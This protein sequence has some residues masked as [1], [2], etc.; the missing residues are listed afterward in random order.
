MTIGAYDGVHIGHRRVIDQVRRRAAAEGLRSVVVTFDR[1]PAA[2]VHPASAPALLTDADQKLDL[3]EATGVDQVLVLQFDDERSKEP[4]EDFVREVLIAELGA[5]IVVVGDDF[6]FGHERRGNVELLR[7]MGADGGFVVEP[8]HLIE[9][10]GAHEVVSSTRIRS[11]V[12]KG[13]LTDAA[14]LLG[15]PHEVRGTPVAASEGPG[16][17]AVAGDP[18][19]RSVVVVPAGIALPPTGRYEG[20]V[21][22]ELGAVPADLI[23]SSSQGDDP[24][25]VEV[26]LLGPGGRLLDGAGAVRLRF[27]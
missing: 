15:R 27:G 22:D 26:G 18:R 24:Q 6:H 10:E 13:A 19:R 16:E 12:A 8:V 5:R 11:L 7:T 2:V 25:L 23:V 20:A 3:L 1:H 4:A 21:V 14:D 17:A 9:D